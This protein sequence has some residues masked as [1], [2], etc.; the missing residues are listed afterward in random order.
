M[1]TAPTAS[2]GG[3][4]GRRTT[5]GSATSCFSFHDTAENLKKIAATGCFEAVTLQYNLLDR[6]NEPAFE[7]VAEK[8]GMGIVVMGPV[9]GGR[10]G[11]ES[12]EIR[13]MIPGARSVPEV[14]LRFVLSNPHVSVALSGMSDMRQLEEN[15]PVASHRT[16]LSAGEKRRVTS[17]M[18]G[19]RSSRNCTAPAAATACPALPAWTSPATS[20]RLNY[21]RVYG[22]KEE[23]RS[24][25]ARLS[26]QGRYCMACGA[27]MSK[28]PQKIDIVRQ[29]RETV[30]TL[31]DGLRA[32]LRA[33]S[34]DGSEGTARHFA[35]TGRRP[36]PGSSTC[37]T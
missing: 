31:D 18:A 24:A 32:S 13:R 14:A 7:F 6:S 27:C 8:C 30:R 33:R 28:C 3:C 29:L 2:S 25:Y 9:G 26:G 37:S 15:V 20:P 34:P 35:R 1:W 36:S 10:L 12:E 19:S 22:L 23:A 16:P 4:S 5:G 11:G 17:I 21:A